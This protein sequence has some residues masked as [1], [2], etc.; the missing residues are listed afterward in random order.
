MDSRPTL[1][2]V[3]A[4]RNAAR[5]QAAAEEGYPKRRAFTA[6]ETVPALDELISRMRNEQQADHANGLAGI[7]VRAG[8][9]ITLEAS[10]RE[11]RIVARAPQKE[12]P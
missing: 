3:I 4:L 11:I 10:D 12:K 2:Q 6:A 9:T 1:A 7:A 8:W 5:E